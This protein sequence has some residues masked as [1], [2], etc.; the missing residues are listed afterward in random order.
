MV[1]RLLP[2]A[3]AVAIPLLVGGLSGIATASSVSTWYQALQRPP[4][5]PP[6]WVFGP[7]WMALYVLMGVASWL[8]WRVGWHDPRV[9]TAL[10]VYG[11]Q[12]G[13]N[14]LWSIIFFG[15]RNPGWALVD[16]I[17]LWA[18][19]VVTLVRFQR[20]TPAA[21]LL[22]VPYALWVTYAATLNGGVWWLNR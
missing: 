21:G 20:V 17:A 1:R 16:I 9:R 7:V 22:L 18:L 6:S 15:L 2:L 4:W 5:T 13:L 19:I 3:V 8:V 11:V 14:F 12:L 10:G